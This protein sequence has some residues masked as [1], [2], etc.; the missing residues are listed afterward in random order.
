MRQL[1]TRFAVSR[2]CVCDLITGHRATGHVAPTPHGGG[3]P[4]KRH[5]AGLEVVRERVRA[6]P[7][8]TLNELGMR[9]HAATQVTA[10]RPTRSRLLR[11]LNWPRQKHV[12]RR[13]ASAPR[14]STPTR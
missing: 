6:E 5:P 3:D 1:A 9:V 8:A 13:R 14:P 2:R 12:P 11:Q 7:D 10:S 4:A